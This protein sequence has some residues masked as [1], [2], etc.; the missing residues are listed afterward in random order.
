MINTIKLAVVA[1]LSMMLVACGGVDT[2]QTEATSAPPTPTT[3]ATPTPAPMNT[4]TAQPSKTAKT[5]P[6]ATSKQDT[7][8]SWR[9]SGERRRIYADF[10]RG[11]QLIKQALENE[12]L[13]RTVYQEFDPGKELSINSPNS[14][15][16]KM[17]TSQPSLWV[18]LDGDGSLLRHA[19]AGA[20]GIEVMIMDK[21]V[22][23]TIDPYTIIT[24]MAEAPDGLKNDA[25]PSWYGC[26]DDATTC[27][28]H[29][30]GA[31]RGATATLD[32]LKRQEREAARLYRA[33]MK[34]VFGVHWRQMPTP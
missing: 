27:K 3:S 21:Q 20:G 18:A 5:V 13:G 14:M 31:S 9:Q 6:K 33:A 23:G 12:R 1:I 25:T 19:I 15:G 2:I 16:P 11:G 32:D 22:D 24:Y 7:L 28:A 30:E 17:D 8:E 29:A 10:T 26:W 4:L 34:E